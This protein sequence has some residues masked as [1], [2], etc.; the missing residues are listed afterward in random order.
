M[1]IENISKD[2]IMKRAAQI[3]LRNSNKQKVEKSDTHKIKETDCY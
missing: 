1:E 2:E 3:L